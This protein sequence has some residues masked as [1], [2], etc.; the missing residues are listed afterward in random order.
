[1]DANRKQGHCFGSTFVGLQLISIINEKIHILYQNP[2]FCSSYGC[3]P[4]RLWFVKEDKDTANEE[5]SRLKTESKNLVPFEWAPGI[6]IFFQG[7]FSMNDNKIENFKWGNSCARDCC[8]CGAKPA[9]FHIDLVFF[10]D[11]VKLRDFAC[12]PLHFLIRALETLLKE[13]YKITQKIMFNYR[14]NQNKLSGA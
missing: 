8:F 3:R 5:I 4:L 11:P 7:F 1:M 9:E 12:S 14:F 10:V 13:S 2:H 6:K